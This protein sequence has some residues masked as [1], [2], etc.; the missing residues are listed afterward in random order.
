MV[1][2]SEL[3]QAIY[4]DRSMYRRDGSKKSARGYLGPIKNKVTGGTMTE[5][6]VG[7]EID[8]K[9]VEVPAMVPTL[10]SSEIEY[11]QEME[12]GKGWDMSNPVEQSI[13]KKAKDHAQK[14]LS[15]GKSVYYQD[16]E[17]KKSTS[18]Q[19]LLNKAYENR[20]KRKQ[21]RIK[22]TG[23]SILQGVTF[24]FA[25][26]LEAMIMASGKAEGD[27][28]E[29]LKRIRA[30]QKRF[31][32]LEPG[33]AI[34]SELAGAIPGGLFAVPKL[35]GKAGIKS[36]AKQAGIEGAVYGFG[37]GEGFEERVGG[38]TVGGLGGFAIGKVLSVAT[39][40]SSSGGLRTQSDE[41]ADMSLDPENLT[42]TQAIQKAQADEVFTEV[43]TPKYT[44]KPLSDAKTFGEFWESATGALTNFYND[45]VTGVSDELM[46]VVSPQ[47]GAR[48][49][50]A[51]ET[52]LRNV[53][54]SLG[55]L[56]EALV[57][58]VK[59]INNSTKAKG[60]LLDY[61]AGK[62]GKTRE[63]SL[64][65]LEKEL[66]KDLNTQQMNTLKAY[67]KV[68]FEKN[69][70][71]NKKVFGGEFSDEITYL[72][73]RNNKFISKLKE[74]G[75]T[76]TEIEKMFGDRAYEPRT[77][78][79]YVDKKGNVPDPSEYDN[80]II[81]DMQRLFKMERLAQLQDKFGVDINV[82]ARRP[83]QKALSPEEFMDAL[84]YSFTQR[85]ISNDGAQYAVNKITDSIMGQQK[86]PHP[87]IQAANSASYATT[88]AGPLSAILNLA[89]IPL[90]GAKYG[91]RAVLEGLQV[92]KPFKSVPNPDLKKLGLDNQTFG[93][94]VNKTNELAD[95][96]QGFM[97]RSAEL[98]RNGTDFLMKGSGFAVMD[99]V[100]KKGVMRGVLRSAVDD[101][102]AGNLA[103]N[104]SFYFNDAELSVLEREFK[105]HGTDW[106]K[107]KGKGSE[108]AEEL[109]FAGLGQQQLISAAGRPAA[110]ARN[111]NLRPLWALRGFVVKQQAL[112]LREVVGNIKAGKPEEAAKFLGRYAM[113]GAGG[114]A[115]INEIRQG[116]FG[117]G[118]MSISGLIRGY[119]DAWASLLTANTLGLN[120]YQY[121][122]IKENGILYTLAEG[123]LPII[124]D[125]P[126]DIGQ[127]VVGALEGERP[128][129]AILTEL[130][131]VKQ[132]ARLGER[133]A[134]AAGAT[135][136]EGMMSELLRQRNPNP[137]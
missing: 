43:D 61:G 66:S 137:N 117:D 101:A 35:L 48:F 44:R 125:R 132:T 9:E 56:A 85:G 13:V 127:T 116:I 65:R 77:R 7:I 60:A 26:E 130:P 96:N 110:W 111:P 36:T 23:R 29:E 105:R 97:A 81:T 37:A 74:D 19:D 128:P 33:R 58:V 47:I 124:I 45:K 64:A 6:S 84:F 59:T 78:G 55:N 24:G 114:Y 113:Y 109:M 2:S 17:N 63:A 39:M 93:E 100:G 18:Y 133:A 94:F 122:Q 20:K 83:G 123:S 53:N 25:D 129:Q 108:L 22:G 10:S 67:L 106:T 126:I 32:Q 75:L 49:Q 120:D 131:I 112:A 115:V 3:L 41:I 38:A 50:R 80:P 70:A 11:M 118:D 90:V 89:D 103:K 91:G 69:S 40:P 104:W 46:R 1:D 28:D 86:T 42:A 95:S 98:M 27:Y 12:P 21:E 87:L 5:F 79:S 72:H 15:E 52:A 62:L 4:N 8:G 119:G 71:L 92:L 14:R 99:Q 16:S 107:Y 76:D 34:G 102:E 121:G 31:E 57:P 54:K 82:I 30:E 51:D 134:G 88:L 73:T 135:D 136:I 68:S